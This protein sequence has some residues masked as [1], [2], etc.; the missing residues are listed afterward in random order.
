[1][2]GG[3]DT[4]DL[5]AHRLRIQRLKGFSARELQAE[6]ARQDSVT[7]PAA[8]TA[9]REYIGPSITHLPSCN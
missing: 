3:Q 7:G 9:D 8:L 5:A 1:M 2:F 6:R 4:A